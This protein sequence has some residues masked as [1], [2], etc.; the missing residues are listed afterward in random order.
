MELAANALTTV[1]QAASYMTLGTV[2]GSTETDLILSINAASDFLQEECGVQFG[3]ATYTDEELIGLGLTLLIPTHAPLVEVTG[4]KDSL[5]QAYTDYVIKKGCLLYRESGWTKGEKFY[6][7]YT[8]GYVLPKDEADA[9]P[10][11]PGVDAVPAVVRTLPYTIEFAC[12]QWIAF[13]W[14][15]RGSEHL[16]SETVGPL[17]YD[18][19]NNMPRTVRSIINHYKDRVFA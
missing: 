16:T 1:A 5:G 3:I 17:K 6:V 9:I 19:L 2:T 10:A 13:N 7:T 14:N 12:I 11:G 4:I 18:Y 8:G 15:R